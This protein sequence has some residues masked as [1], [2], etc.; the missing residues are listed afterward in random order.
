MIEEAEKGVEGAPAWGLLPL[1]LGGIGLAIGLVL[2]WLLDAP[3]DAAG[4]PARQ[5]LALGLSVGGVML[6]L[7]L[8]R[9]SIASAAGFAL[10]VALVAGLVSWWSGGPAGGEAWRLAC[11]FAAIVIAAPLFQAARAAGWARPAYA[12]VHDQGWTNLVL[13]GATCIFTLI[14]W[15][16]AW[17]LATLFGLIELDFL[18]DLLGKGWFSAGLLGAAFGAGLGFLREFDAIVRALRRLVATVLAMLAPVLALGL[19]AFVL[20]M[21]FTGLQPLWKATESAAAVLLACVLGALFLANAVIG[22]GP[23]EERRAAPLRIAAL[24]L[25]L[26]V[27]PLAIVA[28][29]AVGMRIGQHGLTPDRLWATTFVAIACVFGLAC[30]YAVLRGRRDWAATLRPINLGLA[31]FVAGIA[32][33]LATPLPGFNALATRDQVARLQSGR[34]TPEQFDWRALAF[35]FGEPGRAA[36]ARLRASPNAAIRAA[37]IKAG[38][39]EQRWQIPAMDEEARRRGRV[40]ANVRMLPAGTA[41]PP[42]LRDSLADSFECAGANTCTVLMLGAGEAI[43]FEDSCF[44]PP[45]DARAAR[46]VGV[47]VRYARMVGARYDCRSGTRWVRRDGRWEPPVVQA[48]DAAQAAAY[49]AGRIDVA[50]AAARTVRIGGTPVGDPFE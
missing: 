21:P 23:A 30:L 3:F 25:L 12:P 20:A 7:T 39:A 28:A 10:G 32:L 42:E 38:E 5:S 46:M 49:R 18:K 37:A 27:L 17:L 40:A 8:E 13:W 41:L 6:G 48:V 2:Y 1:L 50:P 29:I 35:D 14:V 31:W 4:H 34:V 45:T 16:M 47:G 22:N 24:A 9:G 26:V 36:V 43:Q 15:L 33:L 19:V 11:L 44:A